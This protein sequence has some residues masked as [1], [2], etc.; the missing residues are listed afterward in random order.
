MPETKWQYQR[1]LLL[2]FLACQS[3]DVLGPTQTVLKTMVTIHSH[4]GYRES[5]SQDRHN[6][7]SVRSNFGDCC[8]L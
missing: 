8:C 6:C 3:L 5:V 2:Y 1:Q 7:H 4:E